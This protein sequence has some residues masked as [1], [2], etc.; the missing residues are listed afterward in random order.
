ME[1]NSPQ[2]TDA[3][4]NEFIFTRTLQDVRQKLTGDK[5]DLLRACGLL[6]HLILD[7]AAS[8]ALIVN[9][10]YG[11]K[12][13]FYISAPDGD[14]S[15]FIRLKASLSWRSLSPVTKN[16]AEVNIDRML[17]KQM[18]LIYPHVYTVRDI[19]RIAANIEGGVHTGTNKKER[20]N[21]FV[22]AMQLGVYFGTGDDVAYY[23]IRSICEVVLTGLQPL[24]E[25]VKSNL[26]GG[27][28]PLS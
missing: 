4:V 8:L 24:E 13:M 6:R 10:K 21:L 11:L 2:N 25:A 5:Y 14:F 27:L 18:L 19:I 16:S 12:L 23:S 9:R 17:K 22:D 15:L 26:A 1:N 28:E 7:G 20:D 3:Q